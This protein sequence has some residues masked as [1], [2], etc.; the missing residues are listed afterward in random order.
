MEESAVRELATGEVF[1]ATRG[2]ELGLVD[3]FDGFAEALD[4][5]AQL[6][7][8]RP[9]PLWVRPKR[10]FSARLLGRANSQ[11]AGI[12]MLANQFQ[13]CMGG[14]VLLPGAILLDGGLHGE[15]D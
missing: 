10:P 15:P 2:K 14:G 5:A 9:R 11:H 13:R 7:D 1:T 6:G 3:D 12:S 8:A 4:I